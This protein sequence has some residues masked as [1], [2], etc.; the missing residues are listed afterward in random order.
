MCIDFTCLKK[1]YPKDPFP[2]PRIDQIV[3]ST[4]GC[5]VLS[6]LYAYW[7]YH[8]ISMRKKDEEK[9]TFITPFG[10]FC[11][12]NMHFGLK[13]ASNG[14]FKTIYSPKSSATLKLMSMIF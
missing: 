11:Y 10:V 9:T 1:A 3:D 13:S 4:A 12:V 14:V 6:F 5:A 2:P 7:R 8:Q